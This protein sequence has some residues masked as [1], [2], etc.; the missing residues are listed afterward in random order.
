MQNAIPV[1]DYVFIP[2]RRIQ[3]LFLTIEPAA[4]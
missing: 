1:V 2:Q 3:S 4:W